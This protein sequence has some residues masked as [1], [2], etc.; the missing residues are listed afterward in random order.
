MIKIIVAMDPN[1]VIGNGDELPWKIKEDMQLFKK[2]TTDNVVIMGRKTYASIGKPLPNRINIVISRVFNYL[3]PNV[4]TVPDIESAIEKAKEF[5]NDIYIIGG[6]TIYE[7]TINDVDELCISH[8]RS[9]YSGDKFFPEIDNEI[10]QQNKEV[11][12]DDFIFKNY[13]KKRK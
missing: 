6:Q 3:D 8:I 12:Y 10:W 9:S 2:M 11:Y 4:I 7:Q 13:E 1:N 5:H